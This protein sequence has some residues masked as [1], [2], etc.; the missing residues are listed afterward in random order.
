MSDR[1]TSCTETTGHLIFIANYVAFISGDVRGPF[2]PL[3][4]NDM[5]SIHV[6]FIE[7]DVLFNA[8]V[9]FNDMAPGS[10][11]RAT[12]TTGHVKS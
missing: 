9:H 4:F 5:R 10:R 2:F 6:A 1:V 12:L 7:R 8:M 3:H 11:L